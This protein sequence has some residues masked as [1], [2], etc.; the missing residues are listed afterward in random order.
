MIVDGTER[1]VAPVTI[2]DLAPGDHE[3]S[4]RATAYSARAHGHRAG[5]R[6]RVAGRADRRGGRPRAR[7]PAGSSVKA[8]F[9]MEIREQGRLLG[10]T[11][12]DRLMIAAG[13]HELDF[14]SEALGYRA[15]RVV[16]VAPARSR[17][18]RSTCR[19]VS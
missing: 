15:T 5:W 4:C 13:R 14:V 9:A 7:C 1:G 6:H 10:T 2:T 19:R 3:S 12:T 18:C 8:P 17:R 16:Q 11:D